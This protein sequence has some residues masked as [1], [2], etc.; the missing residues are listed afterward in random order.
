[1]AE[2]NGV[3]KK[4]LPR[5]GRVFE[6]A[7][8]RSISKVGIKK[9][10][11]PYPLTAPNRFFKPDAIEDYGFDYSYDAGKIATYK[12]KDAIITDVKFTTAKGV[13]LEQYY[14]PEQ[15]KGFIDYLA[16]VRGVTKN[17]VETNDKVS[18]YGLATLV[19]ATP[20]G[21]GISDKLINYA[22]EKNVSVYQRVT[23]STGETIFHGPGSSVDN[24]KSS[25]I[26]PLFQ[27]SIKSNDPIIKRMQ[28]EG[29][30]GVNRGQGTG[31]SED[32]KYEKK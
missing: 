3:D 15:I 6:D 31:S 29:P 24:L 14:N 26:F 5:L 1:M 25:A 12:F 20:Y 28:E 4:N 18:D 10:I 21:V 11:Y 17:G 9:D 16:N 7:V 8:L 19:I 30:I 22:K 13:P 27:A 32:I 23:Y 2:Q